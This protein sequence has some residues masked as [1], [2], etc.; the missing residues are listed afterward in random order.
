MTLLIKAGSTLASLSARRGDFEDWV[1]HSLG[2]EP[3]TVSVVDVRAA[4]FFHHR[5]RMSA[6]S[7]SA[8]TAW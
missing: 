2:V 7:Y 4:K 6:S 8:R 5:A 3:S 1:K